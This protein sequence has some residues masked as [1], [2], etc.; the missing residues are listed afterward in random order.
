MTKTETV[1]KAKLTKLSTA[2]L[3]AQYELAIS[4]YSG[5][6]TNFS[7]RQKRIDFIVGLLS[8]RADEGDTDALA[9]YGQ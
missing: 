3:I 6:M 1:A 7:P 2:D 5:R 9:W 4:S 8:D